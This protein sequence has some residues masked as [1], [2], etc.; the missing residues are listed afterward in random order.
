MANFSVNWLK[1]EGHHLAN[2]GKTYKTL[3]AAK[4]HARKLTDDLS[5][6]RSTVFDLVKGKTVFDAMA[7]KYNVESAYNG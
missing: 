5:V 3:G 7:E 1:S 2:Y 6:K 4:R